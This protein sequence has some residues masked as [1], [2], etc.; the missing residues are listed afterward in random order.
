M[1]EI[2]RVGYMAYNLYGIPEKTVNAIM[3]SYRNKRS[4]LRLPDVDTRLFDITVVVLQGDTL[5]PFLFIIY[6]EY[7][8]IK[9]LDLNHDLGFSFVKKKS[10]R[11]Q[12]INIAYVD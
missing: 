7:I 3:I 6:L 2:L 5:V 1:E 9:S 10:R 4:K 8:L 11:H 12:V